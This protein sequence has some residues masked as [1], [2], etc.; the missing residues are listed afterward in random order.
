MTMR[1]RIFCFMLKTYKNDFLYVRRLIKSFNKYNRDNITLFILAPR[2]QLDELINSCRNELCDDIIILAEEEYCKHLVSENIHGFSPGYVNQQIIKLS[3]WEN[4][5]CDNYMCIDSDSIFIR[6]FHINDFMFDR[7]TP[8]SVL[9]EDNALKS[10]PVYY[11]SFWIEREQNI[12]KIQAEVGLPGNKMI[13]CHGFQIF[14]KKVLIDFKTNFMDIKGYSYSALIEISPY[15][16]SWYN[17]WLQKA[18]P[19]DIHF[20]DEFFHYYHMAHQHIYA[21]LS[22]ITINDLA[23]SYVGI[24]LNSNFQN[25]NANRAFNDIFDYETWIIDMRGWRM[26]FH[27][28]LLMQKY[29]IISCIKRT[30]NKVFR[31]F[32]FLGRRIT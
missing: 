16:F 22:G 14:S 18:K 5:L 9:F 24:V 26:P 6:D 8:Y 32:N 28:L 30:I 17:F 29:I 7:D 3:F 20:C 12:K 13:T 21:V 2:V 19:I 27:G 4:N 1:N 25:N 10:D 15:E 23:R 31:L 11:Q